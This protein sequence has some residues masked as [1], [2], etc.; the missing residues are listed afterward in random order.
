MQYTSVAQLPRMRQEE[1]DVSPHSHPV[2]VLLLPRIHLCSK[3]HQ[4]ATQFAVSRLPAWALQK[5]LLATWWRL[6]GYKLL[7]HEQTYLLQTVKS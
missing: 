1:L 6:S 3:T 5:A 7:A 4:G 2:W